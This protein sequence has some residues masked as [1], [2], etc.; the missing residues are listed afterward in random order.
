METIQLFQEI[1]VNMKFKDLIKQQEKPNQTKDRIKVIQLVANT[2]EI[3][4]GR[5]SPL[6]AKGLG[7]P[8]SQNTT[9]F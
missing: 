6:K 7:S 3:D 5:D 8:L 1:A 4:F 2:E 9:Q